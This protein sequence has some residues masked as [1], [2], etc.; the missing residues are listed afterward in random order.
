[1]I[2]KTWDPRIGPIVKRGE[3]HGTQ[4]FQFEGIG[5][6]KGTRRPNHIRR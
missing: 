4:Q 5:L 2:A 1:M 6:I 3:V